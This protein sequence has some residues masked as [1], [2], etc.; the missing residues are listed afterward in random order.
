LHTETP[1]QRHGFLSWGDARGAAALLLPDSR[2]SVRRSW[3]ASTAHD[4]TDAIGIDGSSNALKGV[5]P[6]IVAMTG[7]RIDASA[8]ELFLAVHDAPPG[9]RERAVELILQRLNDG[10]A[11]DG[12]RALAAFC[13]EGRAQA[14]TLFEA[15][16]RQ[17]VQSAC[18][19]AGFLII[20]ILPGAE[21]G[22][23]LVRRPTGP[24]DDGT[25]S[26]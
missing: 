13:P 22:R 21:L 9:P 24:E 23:H 3:T 20:D 4:A 2:S 16:S 11:R 19:A 6:S 17:A 7:P 5:R 15:K 1:K 10:A 8:R 25:L 18:S 12:A 26:P 14:Y